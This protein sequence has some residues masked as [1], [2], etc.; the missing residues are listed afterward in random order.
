MPPPL[1]DLLD[2]LRAE[3]AELV[4]AFAVA[5][6]Q[7]DLEALMAVLDPDVVWRS[8]GGGK[9][10]AS[11]KIQHGADRVARINVALARKY[12]RGESR[13]VDVNGA[14]GAP[15]ASAR[16]ELL[17]PD[18][19]VLDPA[20]A[21]L[22]QAL[23]SGRV[24]DELLTL[25]VQGQPPRVRDRQRARRRRQMPSPGRNSFVNARC[26]TLESSM[27]SFSCIHCE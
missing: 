11:R 15:H 3:Q 5:T 1:S 8:D 27:T 22:A 26:P 13:L 10:V 20:D 4:G 14:G 7:G 18:G 25:S 2:D 23:R 6:A 19:T 17:R 16:A 12:P 24:A 9:V 21:P